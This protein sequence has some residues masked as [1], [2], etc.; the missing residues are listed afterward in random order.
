MVSGPCTTAIPPSWYQS[1][2]LDDMYCSMVRVELSPNYTRPTPT[3][4]TTRLP[5]AVG[6]ENNYVRTYTGAS[7]SGAKPYTRSYNGNSAQIAVMAAP[8]SGN[9]DANIALLQFNTPSMAA[10]GQLA[11]LGQGGKLGQLGDFKLFGSIWS[12]PPWVKISSGNTIGSTF[13]DG[14]T[15]GTAF[16]FIWLANFAGGMLDV[17]GTLLPQFN[18]T[19]ALT[20][21]ARTVSASLRGFQNYYGVKFY[22]ISIQNELNFEEYYNSCIYPTSAEYI[23]AIE[24]VR[25]EL[26]Q[27]PDLASASRSRT[28]RP[29]RR[30]PMAC[31]N[32]EAAPGPRIKT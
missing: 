5:T 27:Y 17:S 1:L 11:Q 31:G 25:T 28:G 23:A 7:T 24:A 14:P 21:Y 6:P 26:N 9:I 12:P 3:T 15:A 29:S 2:Y 19:S 18:N 22:A 4:A 20:Q 8:V 13:A 10:A 30:R 32:T 16:P